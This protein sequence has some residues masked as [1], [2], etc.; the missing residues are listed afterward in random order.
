M[1]RC[2]TDADGQ[3]RSHLAGYVV[4]WSGQYARGNALKRS[5]CG[6]DV[7]P[8]AANGLVRLSV[9]KLHS[10]TVAER[11][12]ERS[13]EKSVLA[14]LSAFQ[15]SPR[16][17]WRES[18]WSR[19]SFSHSASLTFVLLELTFLQLTSVFSTS[20]LLGSSPLLELILPAYHSCRSV[21]CPL[22]FL[23]A[24]LRLLLLLLV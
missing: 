4:T 8:S 9:C 21:L 18:K 6:A 19:S 23:L 17:N 7:R 16:G 20:S 13:A 5:T 24:S 3:C 1:I 12:T 2:A 14:Q 15:S 11:L 22:H 10:M